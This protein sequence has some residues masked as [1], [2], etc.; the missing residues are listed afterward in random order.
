MRNSNRMVHDDVHQPKLSREKTQTSTSMVWPHKSAVITGKTK[1]TRAFLNS[2]QAM[3]ERPIL[4]S[5]CEGNRV[6]WIDVHQP[7]SNGRKNWLRQRRDKMWNVTNNESLPK[8]EPQ[9]MTENPMSDSNQ[10]TLWSHRRSNT[11]VSSQS[12]HHSSELAM[13]WNFVIS[14]QK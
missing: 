12:L 14:F 4:D 2:N 8:K 7:K 13:S 5:S 3:L 6:I 10:L 11:N 9:P 1:V